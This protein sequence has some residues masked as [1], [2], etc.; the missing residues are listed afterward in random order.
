MGKIETESKFTLGPDVDLDQEVLLDGNG[1]RITQE[2]VD[3]LVEEIFGKSE[4]PAA[5]KARTKSA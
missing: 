2:Y 1:N 5:S 4:R 3:E